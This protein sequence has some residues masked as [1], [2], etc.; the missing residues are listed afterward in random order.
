MTTGK[1]CE[2]DVPHKGW[3][4]LDVVDLGEPAK[5]CEMCE[6]ITIRYVHF[7]RHEDYPDTLEVGCVCAGHMAEDY[8]GPARDEKRLRDL[9]R[10]R[11][12]WDQRSW[13]K[14][15]DGR[16]FTGAQYLN[17]EGFHL[18]VWPQR[19]VWQIR[20]G[21]H[22]RDPRYGKKRYPTIDAAK[23][24]GLDALLWAKEHLAK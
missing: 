23:R 9:A 20:V 5:I 1:W 4:R 7:M 17:T 10:R 15:Y 12:T 14:D 13:Y 16:G 21:R 19:G 11:K 2:P 24:A 22:G 18:T 3:Q 6:V 8:V